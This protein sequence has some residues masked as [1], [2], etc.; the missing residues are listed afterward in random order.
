[1]GFWVWIKLET[2]GLFIVPLLKLAALFGFTVKACY[3][4]PVD[5]LDLAEFIGTRV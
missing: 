4:W 5:K 2:V 3:I 1:M